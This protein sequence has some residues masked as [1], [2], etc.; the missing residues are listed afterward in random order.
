M[1]LMVLLLKMGMSGMKGLQG[2]FETYPFES[3]W[4]RKLEKL[5]CNGMR[6]IGRLMAGTVIS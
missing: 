2:L 3:V 6:S 5:P 1:A 4:G